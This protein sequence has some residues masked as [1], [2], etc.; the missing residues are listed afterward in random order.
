MMMHYC[1]ITLERML[2]NLCIEYSH[3]GWSMTIE[4]LYFSLEQG[5]GSLNPNLITPTNIYIYECEFGMWNC[6]IGN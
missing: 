2:L 3:M 4:L 6:P 5:F 1:V